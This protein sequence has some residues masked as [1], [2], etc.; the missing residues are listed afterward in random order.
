M[1]K[2]YLIIMCLLLSGCGSFPEQYEARSTN[3][4]NYI[5]KSLKIKSEP[6]EAYLVLSCTDDIV[7]LDYPNGTFNM[8][9]EGICD[10]LIGG[11]HGSE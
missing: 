9:I 10:I 3:P 5:D 4:D 7:R 11:A 2:I 1:K 6:I 8:T